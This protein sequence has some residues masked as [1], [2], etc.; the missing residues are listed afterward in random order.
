MKFFIKLMRFVCKSIFVLLKVIII[1]LASDTL[2]KS[3]E[4]DRKGIEI[5][6]IITITKFHT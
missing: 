5:I 3:I 4:E 1:V 6:I 2:Y